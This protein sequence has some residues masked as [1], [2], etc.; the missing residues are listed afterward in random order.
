MWIQ[1]EFGYI[2]TNKKKC[3]L[4]IPMVPQPANYHCH[5]WIKSSIF[6]CLIHRFFV[7]L[8]YQ[9]EYPPNP[10]Y[11]KN[12]KVWHCAHKNKQGTYETSVHKG[13]S[14][15]MD[16]TSAVCTNNCVVKEGLSLPLPTLQFCLHV[17]ITWLVWKDRRNRAGIILPY[18][19]IMCNNIASHFSVIIL[20]LSLFKSCFLVW[21]KPQY[22]VHWTYNLADV[23]TPWNPPAFTIMYNSSK[24][25][26]QPPKLAG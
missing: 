25:C 11:P 20:V 26:I 8:M 17:L 15:I 1:L 9:N 16:I 19:Y 12:A 6:K 14:L 2:C 22:Y 23:L 13:K 3:N 24:E 21:N 5:G 10:L 18:S 4:L 7:V